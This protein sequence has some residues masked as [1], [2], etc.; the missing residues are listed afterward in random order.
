[1]S[2]ERGVDDVEENHAGDKGLQN[3]GQDEESA[4]SCR[5]GAN[6]LGSNDEYG[7]GRVQVPTGMHLQSCLLT[8]SLLGPVE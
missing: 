3:G 6:E 1:M 8:A 7:S 4:L 5:Q 2:R